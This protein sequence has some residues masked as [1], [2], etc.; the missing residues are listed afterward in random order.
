MRVENLVGH[1]DLSVKGNWC[2]VA[3]D[4]THY[5]GTNYLS[6]VDCEPSRLAIW[7]KLQ[8]ETAVNIVANL[9][10]VVNCC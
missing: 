8:Q 5:E 1:G 4:V 9:Q 3:A 10:Q 2:R 7:R 6:L